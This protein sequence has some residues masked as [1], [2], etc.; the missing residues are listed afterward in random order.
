MPDNVYHPNHYKINALS[1]EP[2]E[3]T[4]R[5][6]SIIGQ[7]VNYVVRSRFKANFKEDIDKAINYLEI[8]MRMKDMF[9]RNLVLVDYAT[10]GNG[11][12]KA[13]LVLWR[14]FY[15]APADNEAGRAFEDRFLRILID[16]H[17][18]ITLD[19]IKKA[20]DFLEDVRDG[21]EDCIYVN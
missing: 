10:L 12:Y 19:S 4:S 15:E 11:M 6:P 5:L 2:V 14:D 9:S 1:I 18:D 21:V 16:D 7:V 17:Y 8:Q 3:L 20:K 13:M